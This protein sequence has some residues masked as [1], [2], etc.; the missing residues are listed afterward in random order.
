MDNCYFFMAPTLTQE[1]PAHAAQRA[2]GQPVTRR[3]RGSFTNCNWFDNCSHVLA[4]APIFAEITAVA[5]SA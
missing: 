2:A 3:E 1:I 5:M 4:N